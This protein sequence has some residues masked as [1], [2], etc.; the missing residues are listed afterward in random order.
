M[1]FES[2]SRRAPVPE[3]PVTGPG[4]PTLNPLG[5]SV[6]P[7][8]APDPRRVRCRRNGGPGPSD[9]GLLWPRPSDGSEARRGRAPACRPGPAPRLPRRPGG[10]CG[11]RAAQGAAAPV[12]VDAETP[13]A[14]DLR[15]ALFRRRARRGAFRAT[16]FEP[17]RLRLAG[18]GSPAAAR[19]RP[20]Y[21]QPRVAG[22]RRPTR[23]R[24][25]PPG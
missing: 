7:A 2:H 22:V 14:A 8:G 4:R 3:V 10:G 11:V 21:P 9:A 16:P 25:A 12:R 23:P 5:P 18:G 24:R 20:R 6:G 15:G 19:R 1:T 13:R 17:A